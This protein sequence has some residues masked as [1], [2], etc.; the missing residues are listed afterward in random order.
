M[1][2]HI[3]TPK[4]VI[5]H[6]QYTKQQQQLREFGFMKNNSQSKVS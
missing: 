4:D 2:S 6:Q 5:K 3:P 1:N